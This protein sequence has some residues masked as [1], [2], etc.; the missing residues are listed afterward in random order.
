ML[1]VIYCTRSLQTK[2]INLLTRYILN[3]KN[4]SWV[5]IIDWRLIT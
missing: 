4:Q 3:N 1:T 5:V 2:I